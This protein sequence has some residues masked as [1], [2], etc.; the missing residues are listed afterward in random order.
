MMHQVTSAESLNAWSPRSAVRN[1]FMF[2]C[3]AQKCTSEFYTTVVN[4]DRIV[5][6]HRFM[7]WHSRGALRLLLRPTI[8]ADVRA[9]QYASALRSFVYI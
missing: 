9:A 6:I 5:A 7:M 4:V 2:L 1:P 8:V 3:Y